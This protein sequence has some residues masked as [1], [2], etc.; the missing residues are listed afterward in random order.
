MGG[1][2]APSDPGSSSPDANVS[3][4]SNLPPS[5]PSTSDP[6]ASSAADRRRSGSSSVYSGPRPPSY[7]SEDGVSYVVNA[8]PRSIA[9]T[10][11][12][13]L[14]PHPAERGAAD[15]AGRQAAW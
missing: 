7:V 12:V 3:A 11:D 9:P 4:I 8:A 1:S 5:S 15:W 10:T 2:E 13:P 14:P 6:A